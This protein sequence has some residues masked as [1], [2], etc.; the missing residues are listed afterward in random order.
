[1]LNH[2][3]YFIISC[4]IGLLIGIERERSHAEGVQAIGIRSF[5]LFALLGTLA[6]VINHNS[7]TI[8]ISIFVFG[9][10]LL[11]YIK[12]TQFKRK[13]MD[14]GITTEISAGITFGLG[15]ITLNHPLVAIFLSA[16]VLLILLKRERLHFFSRNQLKTYEIEVIALLIILCTGIIPLLPNH[17]IDP[18]QLFNPKK[19]FILLAIIILIQF[20]SYL[21]VRIF[22]QRLGMAIT[23][24]LGGLISSTIIFLN[25]KQLLN[26]YP[27]SQLPALT[28]A[29]YA[30]TATL[31]ELLVILFSA[32]SQFAYNVFIPVITMIIT[33]LIIGGLLT[34]FIPKKSNPLSV[35]KLNPINLLAI[36]YM[37]GF[38]SLLLVIMSLVEHF[39]G[40]KGVLFASFL[41]GLFEL[42]GITLATALLYVEN[43]LS[44]TL[45]AQALYIAITASF[46]SKLFLLWILTSYRFAFYSSCLLLI[47]L[48]SGF[49]S[50]WLLI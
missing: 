33:S 17:T 49:I 47:I 26:R 9:A 1:M 31:I 5:I 45:A 27:N 29:I 21:S 18:W 42:H 6:A 30:I 10:I 12:S 4:I 43:Q 13:L 37:V 19:F 28:T 48:L 25:L 23:C 15:F 3:L 40:G 35:N 34:K 22:G 50:Y 44:L 36:L 32:S 20:G 2:L 24:F 41:G 16:L 7:L 39:I 38:I 8:V 11:S 46:L 14:V